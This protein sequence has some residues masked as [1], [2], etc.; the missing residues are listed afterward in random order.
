MKL[1]LNVFGLFIPCLTNEISSIITTNCQK[2]L[3]ICW[4][5]E[6]TAKQHMNKKNISLYQCLFDEILDVFQKMGIARKTRDD[7][8]KLILANCS[9][10][11]YRSKHDKYYI[12]TIILSDPLFLAICYEVI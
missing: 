12:L 7:F 8:H 4:M 1:A 11:H 10:S 5:L 2:T 3:V 6:T 9:F